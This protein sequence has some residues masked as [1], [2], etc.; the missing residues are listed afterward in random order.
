MCC[1]AS[2]QASHGGRGNAGEAAA[3]PHS[4]LE[5]HGT[6]CTC[7]GPF[8]LL[9][10]KRFWNARCNHTLF[11]APFQM[12]THNTV[13]ALGSVGFLLLLL[14][15][16]MDERAFAVCCSSLFVCFAVLFCGASFVSPPLSSPVCACVRVCFFLVTLS[17]CLVAFANQNEQE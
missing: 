11:P 9:C 5:A 1:Y 15:G 10:L 4:A 7:K 16:G 8:C 13:A 12:H 6:F 3:T 14:D 17:W 2:V